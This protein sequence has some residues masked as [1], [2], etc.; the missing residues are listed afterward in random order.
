MG[1]LVIQIGFPFV[2]SV[3]WQSGLWE[4]LVRGGLWLSATFAGPPYVRSGCPPPERCHGVSRSWSRNPVRE[5][6]PL[7]AHNATALAVV[8]LPRNSALELYNQLGRGE[9]S[10]GRLL[11]F[12]LFDVT[13]DAMLQIL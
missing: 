12:R 13:K 1:R 6:K 9:G 8:T 3:A 11:Q 7:F 5:P 10:L 4:P 2:G